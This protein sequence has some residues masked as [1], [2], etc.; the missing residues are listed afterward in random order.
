MTYYLQPDWPAPA[1]IRAYT[2]TRHGG[3]STGPYASFNLGI[4]TN[5]EFATIA[6][7]HKKLRSDLKLPSEPCWLNQIHSNKVLCVDA[8]FT[9]K[10]IDK[11][12]DATFTYIPN[13]ICSV[14]T[15]DCIPI[16]LCDTNATVVAAIHAGWKS[17]V[18]GIIEATI[19]AIN[20]QRSSH[21]VL[22]LLVWLGPAIG[23]QAFYVGSE[24]RAKFLACDST[25]KDAFV[26][27]ATK[28]WLANIYLLAKQRFWSKGITNIFGGEFCTFNN[29]DMFY[30]YRRDNGITGRMANLI[31]ID[32]SI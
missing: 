24:V 21:S 3:F 8:T 28:Q 6:A 13:V 23:P 10:T 5:D 2:T 22:D 18:A 30:S 9:S 29:C 7:N 1:K 19:D 25:A 16:M 11:N 4:N 32:R 27:T 26:Q 14:L 12:A 20:K 15:A 17:I 31:W